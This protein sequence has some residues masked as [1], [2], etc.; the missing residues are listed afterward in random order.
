M[1]MAYMGLNDLLE[2]MPLFPEDGF[3]HQVEV[4]GY[5]GSIIKEPGQNPGGLQFIKN[6][7]IVGAVKLHHII[8]GQTFHNHHLPSV[9]F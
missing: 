1:A 9:C 7:G 4:G 8:K 2:G 6:C 3:R 5:Y